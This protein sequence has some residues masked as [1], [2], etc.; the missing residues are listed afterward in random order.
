MSLAAE[1]QQEH[2]F[3]GEEKALLNYE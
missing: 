2:R 3:L 1:S